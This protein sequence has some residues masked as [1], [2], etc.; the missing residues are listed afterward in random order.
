M[1]SLAD[2][3][4]ACDTSAGRSILDQAI[5]ELDNRRVD[6]TGRSL[7]EKIQLIDETLPRIQQVASD[8]VAAGT[9]AKGTDFESPLA[10]E[11][12]LT[13]P[14]ITARNLRLIRQSLRDIDQVGTPQLP[15]RPY[16]Q[17]GQVVAPVFPTDRYDQ[18]DV[19]RLPSCSLDETRDSAERACQ[20]NGA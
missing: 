13:G 11:E 19:L 5:Q 4:V 12:W 18:F 9:K 2:N 6:W 1:F 14:Y 17:A 8:W 15:G 7:A 20:H 3:Q 10:G 16:V